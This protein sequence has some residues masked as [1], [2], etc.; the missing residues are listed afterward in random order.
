MPDTRDNATE[1]TQATNPFAEE[2][3][4]VAASASRVE[5]PYPDARARRLPPDPSPPLI[6]PDDTPGRPRRTW[7]WLL[8]I[9]AI[10]A[11]VVTGSTMLSNR[12]ESGPR[13]ATVPEIVGL[14]EAE[15]QAKIAAA[16]FLYKNEGEEP[17]ADLPSG[18]VVRQDPAQSAKLEQGKKVAYWI[19]QNTGR[20]AVPDVVRMSQTDA[21]Y[22]LEMSGLKVGL[23]SE[24][25]STE[26]PGTVLR[27]NP[28]AGR[29]ADTGDTVTITVA[30]AADTVK[31]P[32][33]SG[34]SQI[35]AL[36]ALTALHLTATVELVASQVPGGT[37]IGQ[38]PA[39]GAD[40]RPGS[41]VT[42]E[43]SNAPASKN[44]MV[45]A[46]AAIGLTQAQAKAKLLQFGFKVK[47][48]NQ[49]HPDFKPGLCIY[50]S[51]AAGAKVKAGTTV[52]I[53]I[54]RKPATTTTLKPAN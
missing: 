29:Q 33:L 6:E 23:N 40:V 18:A 17:S 48:V 31:V 22:R 15:A 24:V 38:S 21:K 32:L 12:T 1:L 26:A 36:A 30:T 25:N 45:P 39:A 11:L 42:V 47:V 28:E 27:Q 20:V 4:R 44:V 50:Q 37:V 46:V 34:M 41:S 53:F 35:N 3:A 14:S 7:P 19:S 49:E 43:V 9:V 5:G 52:T 8:V 13:V 16:G 54:A 2:A 10:V 51:P